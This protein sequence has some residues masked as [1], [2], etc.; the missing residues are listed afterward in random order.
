MTTVHALGCALLVAAGG[1]FAVQARASGMQSA[2]PISSSPNE[3]AQP[4]SEEL[5]IPGDLMDKLDSKTA[6][7]G[8]RV[9]VRSRSTEHLA[10]GMEIPKGSKLIGR[11]TGVKPAGTANADAQV[12]VEFDRAEFKDGQSLSIQG[13]IRSLAPGEDNG[14]SDP[15]SAA[16]S[17]ISGGRPP[18][19]MYGSTP[20]A[21]PPA[22]VPN[23]TQAGSPAGNSPA[24][25]GAVIARS[26]DL[27]I[28]TTAL[29]GLLLV[30]HEEAPR[31]TQLS[32]ILLGAR[33]DVHLES[34]TH[35]VIAVASNTNAPPAAAN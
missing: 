29:P 2:G 10:D 14:P 15:M 22:Q 5:L 21:A 8:D 16:P 27:V 4:M 13:Q 1:A 18:G 17:S 34:G 3:I 32:S 24:T 19:D 33:R 7:V 12:A 28:R 31:A 9:V 20:S 26:G 6:K 35:I 30:N 23:Q 11:V 25:P